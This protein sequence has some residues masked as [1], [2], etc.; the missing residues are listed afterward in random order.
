ILSDNV[1]FVYSIQQ[2]ASPPGEHVNRATT[3]KN[4][5]MVKRLTPPAGAAYFV[6]VLR[7]NG[8]V[9][10]CAKR[11]QGKL[12]RGGPQVWSKLPGLVMCYSQNGQ[13]RLSKKSNTSILELGIST[14]TRPCFSHSI[15]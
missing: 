5:F 8:R 12:S 13:Q 15:S 14:V 9:A 1:F 6:R 10:T 7:E 2:L 4:L 11:A 3:T